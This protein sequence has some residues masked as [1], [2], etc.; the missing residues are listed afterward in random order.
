VL[1]LLLDAYSLLV[2]IA[3][4]LSWV[5]VAPDNPL[6]KATDVAVEPVLEQIRKVLP[7]TGGFDFSPLVL[8]LGL[9]FLR[10]LLMGGI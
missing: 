7:A 10:S 1:S 8:L 6:R 5:Q 2:F 3:V 9:R 4:I